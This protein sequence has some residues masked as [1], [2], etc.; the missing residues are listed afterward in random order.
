MAVTSSRMRGISWAMTISS[1]HLTKLRSNAQ[2]R[3]DEHAQR[4]MDNDVINIP[5]YNFDNLSRWYYRVQEV[6]QHDFVLITYGIMSISS[7]IKILTDIIQ[8]K[9]AQ[10]GITAEV[11]LSWIGLDL[12]RLVMTMRR[13]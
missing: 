13:G 12:A 7:F 3:S 11:M 6:T 1:S 8:L 9:S 4:I 5:H 2:P 10:T